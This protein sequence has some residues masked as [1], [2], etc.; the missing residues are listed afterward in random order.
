MTTAG[1]LACSI[2]LLYFY[3]DCNEVEGK[4]EEDYDDEEDEEE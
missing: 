1:E 2:S 3:D 4:G